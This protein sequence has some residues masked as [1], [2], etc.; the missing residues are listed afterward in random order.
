MQNYVIKGHWLEVANE[1]LGE[2]K[3]I[4]DFVSIT[5][6][7]LNVS[8]GWLKETQCLGT[9][10]ATQEFL[11]VASTAKKK[12]VF[13]EFIGKAVEAQEK[14]LEELCKIR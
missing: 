10:L 6:K 7:P 13:I 5:S 3:A 11:Y 14:Y 2:L 8:R 1:T 4:Q 12:V 9:D